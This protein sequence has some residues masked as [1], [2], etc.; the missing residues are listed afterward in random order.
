MPYRMHEAAVWGAG[1]VAGRVGRHRRRPLLS[2]RIAAMPLGEGLTMIESSPESQASTPHDD[3]T[4]DEEAAATLDRG[5]GSFDV[6]QDHEPAVA[7]PDSYEYTHE[8]TSL[9]PGRDSSATVEG[10]IVH[11]FH[12]TDIGLVPVGEPSAEDWRACG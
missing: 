5:D 4:H 3:L 9:L 6:N 11:S 1:N 7:M 10:S 8:G 12:I 2:H